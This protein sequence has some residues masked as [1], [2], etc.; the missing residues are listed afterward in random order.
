MLNAFLLTLKLAYSQWLCKRYGWVT[1]ACIDENPA[2]RGHNLCFDKTCQWQPRLETW[3]GRQKTVRNYDRADVMSCCKKLSADST[4]GIRYP[5]CGCVWLQVRTR[6]IRPK[7][8][9]KF[10]RRNPPCNAE[11][12]STRRIPCH[13]SQVQGL[14]RES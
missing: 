13:W 3:S 12:R 9:L 10:G 7:T 1:H 2:I 11:D 4:R 5:L 8:I 6:S 14:L